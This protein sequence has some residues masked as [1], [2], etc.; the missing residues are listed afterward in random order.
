[1]L[2]ATSA[3]LQDL[4]NFRALELDLAN[5]VAGI[6]KGASSVA[7]EVGNIQKL[8][9]DIAGLSGQVE[10][11]VSEGAQMLKEDLTLAPSS[12]VEQ[13]AGKTAMLAVFGT[14]KPKKGEPEKSEALPWA[15]R[16]QSLE[17][18]DFLGDSGFDPLGLFGADPLQ[19][20]WDRT[21]YRE[22]EIKHGRL[23][24]LAALAYPVQERIE[25]MLAKAFNLPDELAATA[26]RSPSLVNGGL[27]QGE[28]PLTLLAFLVG[29]GV[30]EYFISQRKKA[31]GAAYVL[32]DVGFDPLSV[33][34]KTAEEQQKQQ[35][36]ELQLGRAAMV[37]V[38]CYV[39]EEAS[40]ST[41]LEATSAFLQDFGNF[42]AL[43]LDLANDVAGIEKG[44]SSVVNEVGNIQKLEL[45][46]AGLSG[47][48][49]KGVSEGA[50]MLKEDLTMAP[51]SI[52]DQK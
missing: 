28:I 21:F 17:G 31:E 27:E 23:G 51:S 18:S 39:L 20:G 9:L 34:G 36:M 32:G 15:N 33:Y 22:A 3:F 11:G 43:E 45:D 44:A 46:I 4:G 52:L 40:G 50:E 2:E 10:K 25:P 14:Q 37:A 12:V 8:E 29:G 38:L 41:M 26:G 1:M 47:Q 35:L 19:A 49:E 5:D 48:V 24:M 30:V 6:E 16:P 7:N 13:A 42:R